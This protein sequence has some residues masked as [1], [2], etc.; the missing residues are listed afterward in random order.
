[1]AL[2]DSLFFSDRL[3]PKKPLTMRCSKVDIM[4]ILYR[5]YAFWIL[6]TLGVYSRRKK[7]LKWNT[8]KALAMR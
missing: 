6:R 5:R 7:H 4:T 8:I 3:L 2:I 1:M